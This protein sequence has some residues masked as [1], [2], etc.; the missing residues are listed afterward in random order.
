MNKCEFF[1][2]KIQSLSENEMLLIDESNDSGWNEQ[3][4]KNVKINKNVNTNNIN[5][6]ESETKMSTII[7]I[8]NIIFFHY[9]FF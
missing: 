2:K 1:A 4:I 9:R 8:I 7:L 3:K 6:N 5:K